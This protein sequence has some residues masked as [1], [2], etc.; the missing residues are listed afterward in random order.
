LRKRRSAA[1]FAVSLLAHIGLAVA[2]LVTHPPPRFAEP[3]T[4]QI[5]LIRP[6]PR[7]GPPPKPT[8]AA[9]PIR[10]HR[11][12]PVTPPPPIA[13]LI[14]PP[15]PPTAQAAPAGPHVFT[16]EELLAGPKPP[17]EQLRRGS[18]HSAM[19][20]D[21]PLPLPC[22]PADRRAANDPAPPCPVFKETAEGRR[23]EAIKTYK[24]QY[25]S[26]GMASPNDYP[27]LRCTFLHKHC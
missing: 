19:V 24:G 21:G 1:V 20:R 13:P 10:L 14:A 5:E 18:T 6:P 15:P 4:M 16:D 27:G 11:A 17:I 26:S 9:P 2:W 8:R 25:G 7:A 3:V 12:S 22:K 23:K